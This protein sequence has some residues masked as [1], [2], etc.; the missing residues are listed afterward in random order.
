[1]FSCHSELEDDDSNISNIFKSF[2]FN[3]FFLFSYI[4]FIKPD[5]AVWIHWRWRISG[6]MLSFIGRLWLIWLGAGRFPHGPRR[7]TFPQSDF[8]A[9]RRRRNDSWLGVAIDI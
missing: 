2:I 1:M 5:I 3:V 4:Y 8:V 9:N 6:S 7:L